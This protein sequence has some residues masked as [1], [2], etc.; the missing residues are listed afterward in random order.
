MEWVDLGE[1]RVDGVEWLAGESV[2]GGGD[3]DKLAGGIV[4][5]A[6]DATGD[7]PGGAGGGQLQIEIEVLDAIGEGLETLVVGDDAEGGYALGGDLQLNGGPA[8]A[9][10]FDG[11]A[12]EFIGAVL[13]EL[14]GGTIFEGGVGG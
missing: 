1:M 7:G 8:E 3:K 4:V 11:A 9:G 6:E 5:A 14:Q 12:R 2:T 10:W 13:L